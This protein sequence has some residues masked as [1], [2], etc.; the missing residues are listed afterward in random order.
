MT[1]IVIDLNHEMANL[2]LQVQVEGDYLG[3]L[4]ALGDDEH[5]GGGVVHVHGLLGRT[6]DVEQKIGKLLEKPKALMMY[7]YFASKYSNFSVNI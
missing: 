7:S 5:H 2:D 6:N 3:L 1:K 4:L